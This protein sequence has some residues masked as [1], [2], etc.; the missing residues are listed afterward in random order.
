MFT[1]TTCKAITVH[2]VVFLQL[3]ILQRKQEHIDLETLSTP[4]IITQH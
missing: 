2:D 3:Q 4:E 1:L